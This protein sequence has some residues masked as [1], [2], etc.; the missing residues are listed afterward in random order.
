MVTRFPVCLRAALAFSALAWP[1]S[2]LLPTAI[3]Q[4]RAEPATGKQPDAGENAKQERKKELDEMRRRA[5][6]TAVVRLDSSDRSPAKLVAEP[7]MRY[8]NEVARVTDSTI[9]AYGAKGR[10]LA[11][12]ETLCV[13]IPSFPKYMYGLYS[14]S[15]GLIEVRWPGEIGWSSSRPGIAMQALPAGPKPATTETGR[16][17]Q[18]KETSRRF[19]ATMSGGLGGPEELRLLARPVYRYADAESGQQDEA[20]FALVRGTDP[21]CLV[22]IELQGTGVEHAV[23]KYGPVRL[24]DGGL[25]VRLDGNEVWTAESRAGLRGRYETWLSFF[26]RQQERGR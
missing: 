8:S 26:A 12:Q 3:A 17:L 16:L 14:L 1:L 19:T 2:T 4:D 25:N 22:L 13:R 20:I 23:W 18:M 7:L 9:W 5:E 6:A 15:D 11:I 10:P 24:T 21:E